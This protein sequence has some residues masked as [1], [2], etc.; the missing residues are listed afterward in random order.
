MVAL[1]GVFATTVGLLVN[2]LGGSPEREPRPIQD[3]IAFPGS[4]IFFL[5]F[6]DF[7]IWF[8]HR[9]NDRK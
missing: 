2:A 7:M 1:A 9:V 8:F 4:A 5:V 3:V 6:G